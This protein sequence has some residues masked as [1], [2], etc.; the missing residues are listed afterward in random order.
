MWRWS[1]DPTDLPTLQQQLQPRSRLPSEESEMTDEEYTC[2]PGYCQSLE[3]YDH[4]KA[5]TEQLEAA[6]ADA[7]EAEVY[8]DELAGD[9]VDLC[10]QLIAAEDKLAKAVEALRDAVDAWDNH[11]KTGDMMQGHWV[12]DARATLAEIEGEKT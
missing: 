7:K 1:H 11:N 4:I 5:L 3:L 8:A 10:S 9:Q 6:R 12:T 2:D